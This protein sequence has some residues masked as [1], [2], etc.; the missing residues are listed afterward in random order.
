MTR[1]QRAGVVGVLATLLTSSLFAL[2]ADT[3]TFRP[4][5][6]PELRPDLLRTLGGFV[7]QY[8]PGRSGRRDVIA[9]YLP[10]RPRPIRIPYEVIDGLAIAEGDIILGR[11]ADMAVVERQRA[12]CRG[13]VCTVR[14]PLLARTG[15]SYLWPA[16]VIPY[17]IDAS[18]N[19]TMRD[20]IRTA[21]RWINEQTNLLMV[22]RTNERDYVHFRSVSEGCSSS[23]GRMGGRQE[24]RLEAGCA[25][26]NA[27]HEILHAA[28]VWHEHSRH[29][30]DRFVRILWDNIEEGRRHNFEQVGDEGIDIGEYDYGS[31]MH[32]PARAFG[33]T[34]PDTRQPKVTIEVLREGAAIGQ[35]AGLS[36]LD[37]DGI[38][39]IYRAE[40]CLGF[41]TSNA[42]VS[43]EQGRWKIVDGGHWIFDFGTSSRDRDEAQRT[44]QIIQHYRMN[45]ICYVGRPNASAQYLLASGQA[46]RGALAGE[47][48]LR[49][50]TGVLAVRLWPRG[51]WLIVEGRDHQ[52]MSFPNAGEAYRTLDLI[53]QYGFN[54]IC[55]VGRPNPSFTYFR[56]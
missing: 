10:G 35:R 31:I 18:F 42:R 12:E 7:E 26:G 48:C 44:L 1:R 8:A 28:G 24:I 9:F 5:G 46:P 51:G 2:P 53:T 54:H 13:D 34:D 15:E 27:A 55:Y 33:K 19:D 22:E 23:V 17:T 30:R 21:V 36:R 14:S 4:P 16:G 41:N 6:G 40:D 52:M 39:Q 56:R 43:R 50:D 38:N 11:A 29:D 3:Q 20:R 37:T 47:D 25:V 49:F 45:Q 32:Y